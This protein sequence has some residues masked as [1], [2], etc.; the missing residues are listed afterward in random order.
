MVNEKRLKKAEEI[1]R[2]T[3]KTAIE[4]GEERYLQLCMARVRAEKYIY[5]AIKEGYTL[6]K[7]DE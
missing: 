4:I 7:E 5:D 1:I 6:V 2:L 3:G